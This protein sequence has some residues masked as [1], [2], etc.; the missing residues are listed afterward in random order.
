MLQTKTKIMHIHP[1]C[2]NKIIKTAIHVRYFN[3]MVKKKKQQQQ[4]TQEKCYVLPAN[5]TIK[6]FN[7]S[8]YF[9]FFFF[10]AFLIY[11]IS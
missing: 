7:S 3:S 11:Y 2:K 1:I 6:T 4:H 9:F 8:F 5:K 10:F